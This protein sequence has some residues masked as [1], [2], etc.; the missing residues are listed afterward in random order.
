LGRGCAGI[1]MG[2][3][4]AGVIA[5]GFD[6]AWIAIGFTAIGA[7]GAAVA[8]AT[9]GFVS[10]TGDGEAAGCGGPESGGC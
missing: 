1:E 7:T 8:V 4:I 10:F 6:V 2:I 5:A 3:G 9:S